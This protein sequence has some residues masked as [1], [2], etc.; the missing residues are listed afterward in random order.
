MDNPVDPALRGGCWL[1]DGCGE[2]ETDYFDQ[3]EQGTLTATVGCPVCVDNDQSWLRLQVEKERDTLAAD[4]EALIKE[5][6]PCQNVLYQLAHVGQCT[7]SYANDARAVLERVTGGK[8][9]C[10]EDGRR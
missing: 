3:Q 8:P 2:I 5:L 10:F 4:R 7:P 9:P 6:V 1:C